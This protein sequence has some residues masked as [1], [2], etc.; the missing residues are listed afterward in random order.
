[1]RN[2]LPTD[3]LVLRPLLDTD[4][5]AIFELGG[6]IQV[7]HMLQSHANPFSI[8]SAE[9]MIMDYIMRQRRGLA[10]A[11]AISRAQ[12]TQLIGMVKLM[13]AHM[14][15][16]FSLNIWLGRPFWKRGYARQAAQT[17]LQEAQHS[18]GANRICANVFT[19]NIAGLSLLRSLG[20]NTIGASHGMF[21]MARMENAPALPFAIELNQM[22]CATKTSIEGETLDKIGKY[23]HEV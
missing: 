21:S 16:P 3:D 17:V 6:D 10:F 12:D 19:D 2:I 20:F 14:E 15:S 11:Y 5:P 1:M 4:A 8:L 23:R 18:L 9:F 22:I 7:S 13:I